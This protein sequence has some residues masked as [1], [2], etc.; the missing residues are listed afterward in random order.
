MMTK[1]VGGMTKAEA[2]A[3]LSDMT[4]SVKP[5][6]LDEYKTRLSKAQKLIQEAG[7]QAMYIN[8]GSNLFYFTGTKLNASERMIGAILPAKG[9]LIYIAPNFEIDTLKGFIKVDGEI[10][11]WHE[12]ECP[13]ELTIKLLK[14]MGIEGGDVGVDESANFFLS[15]GLSMVGSD[16][17]FT[18]AK[19][20]TAG[21]RMCKS[22]SELALLQQAK[23]MTIE[24]QKATARILVEGI[25]TAEVKQFIHDAHIK[26]GAKSGSSFCIV[27]FGV[28]SS[29]PHGVNKPNPLKKNDIVLIDTG[30]LLEGYNSDITRTYVFGEADDYQRKMWDIEKE[31]QAQAF[32][33][34]QLGEP[35]GDVDKA[36]RDYLTSCGLGPD[37]NV[38]GCPHRTGHGIG[39]D[40][41]EWPY[42]V[43]NNPTKLEVGMCFSNEPMLVL[44]DEF[45]VR[46]EDHF[47]M[48]EDG[49]KW[50]TEPS[51]SIDD[52]FGY[53]A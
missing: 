6:G 2:L 48:S 36:A 34:A 52:P 8:A 46:L 38:P 27:L 4:G 5:I 3:G 22:K 28:D 37:Y 51:H 29:F 42:L 25:S 9:D 24:V 18:S 19:S 21:C 32:R 7:L 35:C 17:K 31:A 15:D 30:C 33:A 16:Y 41:H 20:V 39:L 1:G 10:H 45:G 49:P 23:N 47:Y 40:L 43:K 53:D 44:P 26:V 11:G 50:F 12:D 13:Y 14:G